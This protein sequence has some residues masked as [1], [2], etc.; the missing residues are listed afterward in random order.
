MAKIQYQFDPDTLSYVKVNKGFKYFFK[1]SFIL[2]IL[3]SVVGVL[4]TVAFLAVVDSPKEK[5][6][7]REI[8]NLRMQIELMNKDLDQ[9][10]KILE[11]IEQR[12]DNIYRVIFEA[13]PIPNSIRQ[14]GFGGSNRYEHL[15]DMDNAELVIGTR[16]KLDQI[17]KQ[18]FI[19]SKSLD[20]I[21][22]L[23]RNKEKMLRSIPA[24][25]PIAKKNLSRVA[26]GWGYR[27]HPIY[28]T[29]RFHYGMDFTADIGTPIYATGDGVVKVAQSRRTGY[30]NHIE[31]DHGY[32]YTTL[33]GHLSKFNVKRG[34]RV[35]RGDVIAFSGNTGTSS[36][37]H[38]HYEVH[39]NGKQIDPKYFYYD[40][41]TP[42]EYERMIQISTNYGQAF[43]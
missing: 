38:L 21:V 23:A 30:G 25:M 43:D 37:P 27:I 16:M 19:Q 26:S 42:E 1:Y 22:E 11:D 10:Q 28:K 17:R 35:K 15:K 32:G 41:L 18:V 36:G 39:K 34:T 13:E 14:A 6:Q 24:V 5:Q 3:S 40:D 29:R 7:K 2:L 8:A 4:L 12:D 33:Y 9:V 20:E 31:I